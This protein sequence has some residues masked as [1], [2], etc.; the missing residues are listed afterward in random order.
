MGIQNSLNQLFAASV[1]VGFAVSQ[2]T[3]VR[4][5][6]ENRIARKQADKEY[7]IA[8]ET[9][10]GARAVARGRN[11]VLKEALDKGATKE[12]A[13]GLIETA[14]KADL[15][16]ADEEVRLAEV[17]LK[18]AEVY[19]SQGKELPERKKVLK[20]L[21]EEHGREVKDF[22]GSA[23]R[24][25]QNDL[26]KAYEAKQSVQNA[27]EARRQLVKDLE[28]EREEIRKEILKK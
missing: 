22:P 16:A 19:E 18:R 2:S 9:A 1:G 5:I 12:S 10:R 27:V 15:R 21:S 20:K 6:A 24:Q 28:K 23:S 26:E 7:R 25:A 4:Q 3:G 13:E 11:F 8:S 17:A 14:Q